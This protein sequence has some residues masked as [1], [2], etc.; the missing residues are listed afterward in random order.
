LLNKS[1]IIILDDPFSAVDMKTEERIIENLRKN[2]RQSLI[3]LIS[4]R[5]SIFKSIDRILLLK[6]DKSYEWG[7]HQEL[8]DTSSLYAA[9]FD[10]QC[11]ESGDENG[12]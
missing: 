9:I 6:G 4:H 7:S 11:K 10:L 2:Y 3:I 1:K 8:M 5:L 12:R